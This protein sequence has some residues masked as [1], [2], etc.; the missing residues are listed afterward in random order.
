MLRFL[1]VWS[2]LLALG[3]LVL[4]ATALA[5]GPKFG[6]VDVRTAMK[7]TK[8]WKDAYAKLEREKNQR[9][10]LIEVEKTK[11]KEK[12][13]ALEAKKAVSDPKALAQEEE[14]LA[15]EAQKFMRQFQM[16]Q[17]MLSVMEQQL[18]DQMLQRM[19]AV[20]KT[21]SRQMELD[22]VFEA[23][24]DGKPNVLYA[25]KGVDITNKVAKAYEKAY[26]DQ[27]LKEPQLPQ[28]A[29]R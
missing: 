8:H 21:I 28:R 2:S 11:L 5:K 10:G 22:F 26:K 4:P 27:P 17:Q 3:L 18:A 9:Q 7:K 14:A 23:G 6:V 20:V 25:A 29:P 24:F 13:D 19:E 12:R 15:M 16:N 1:P